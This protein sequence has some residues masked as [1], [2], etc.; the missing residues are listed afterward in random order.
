MFGYIWESF[1][2]WWWP[3]KPEDICGN[4]FAQIGHPEWP[5]PEQAKE[6]FCT[7]EKLTSTTSW[8][9]LLGVTALTA[10]EF[11][12][13]GGPKY[14][15]DKVRT[16]TTGELMMDA[17]KIAMASKYGIQYVLIM[18]VISKHLD[19]ILP[20]VIDGKKSQLREGAFKNL[21][22]L[23]FDMP[24]TQAEIE[25]TIK[26]SLIDSLKNYVKLYASEFNEATKERQSEI[27]AGL[28]AF[29]MD[30]TVLAPAKSTTSDVITPVKAD[31]NKLK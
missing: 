3:T 13:R 2:N 10:E 19:T 22:K 15:W 7:M 23:Q 26:Q 6:L 1:S 17:V 24:E 4:I 29:C 28:S 18:D 31:S 25:K 21:S 16:K 5:L 9:L 30:G 27:L 8:P 14:L 11:V 20:A 12:R